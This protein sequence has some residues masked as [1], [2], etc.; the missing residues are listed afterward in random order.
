LPGGN[1]M[2]VDGGHKWTVW[3]QGVQKVFEAM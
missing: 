3:S 1:V 2:V